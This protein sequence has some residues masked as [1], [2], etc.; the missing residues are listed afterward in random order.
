MST[1]NIEKARKSPWQGSSFIDISLP[2]SIKGKKPSE[3]ARRIIKPVCSNLAKKALF[4]EGRA[5]SWLFF[6]R[7][8]VN[9]EPWNGEKNEENRNNHSYYTPF[10]PILSG[11]GDGNRGSPDPASDGAGRGKPLFGDWVGEI[12]RRFLVSLMEAARASWLSDAALM[13]FLPQVKSE[14]ITWS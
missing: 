2:R 4:P 3:T 7:F 5:H 6:R 9:N 11:I 1:G 14:D 10:G 12:K 8:S 13:T